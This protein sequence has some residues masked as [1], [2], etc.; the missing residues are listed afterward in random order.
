MENKRKPT[1]RRGSKGPARNKK[2]IDKK[3]T[4]KGKDPEVM[5]PKPGGNDPRW[6]GT[7]EF[8]KSVAQ[9]NFSNP[10]G[11]PIPFTFYNDPT[12]EVGYKIDGGAIT[13][14]P[15]IMAIDVLPT[16][17]IARSATDSVNTYIRSVFTKLRSTNNQSAPY[18][19]ADLGM[20][21]MAIDSVHMLIEQLVR[22]YGVARTY[23]A[24][25]RYLP[26]AM[27]NAMG[28]DPNASDYSL[29]GNL[30]D[31][32]AEILNL[33]L[34]I[35]TLAIPTGIKICERH[36]ELVKH[37]YQDGNSS[38]SQTYLFR[39]KYLYKFKE[40][41]ST[42]G[43]SLEAIALPI[44]ES[45]MRWILTAHEL[46]DQLTTSQFFAIVSGDIIKSFGYDRLFKMDYF[47]EMYA[48]APIYNPEIL[49]EIHNMKLAGDRF[50]ETSFNVTQHAGFN[51]L[52]AQP[53][54]ASSVP[55][56]G[57]MS[58]IIDVPVNDPD[59][60]M[61]MIS[62]RLNHTGYVG[63]DGE[64]YKYVPSSIGTELPL[65]ISIYLYNND[66]TLRVLSTT[67][68]SI[69]NTDEIR[70]LIPAES[71]FDWHPLMYITSM[72][73]SN[74]YMHGAIGDFGNYTVLSPEDLRKMHD[75]A[76]FAS[77][78]MIDVDTTGIPNSK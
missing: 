6:W 68:N 32:R 29:Y 14:V 60:D 47:D 63:K 55:C 70:H 12:S 56:L 10:L 41:A 51:E 2:P 40:T 64:V 59:P 13:T 31:F 44:G 11:K 21:I 5:D 43:S 66:G 54:C 16:V 36:R 76:I 35:Q 74:M 9:F 4:T 25:N 33:M 73:G 77:L 53:Y 45:A 23:S 50:N 3:I 61:V 8:V 69:S 20:Y 75:M 62:T 39:T 37:I 34:K 49:L 65:G 27:L 78:T 1:F 30:A 67:T 26:Q 57:P 22:M 18:Q 42:E 17:G 38:K 48:V 46:I 7:P 71:N 52:V 19:A 24:M 15:G 28:V 58:P 72:S